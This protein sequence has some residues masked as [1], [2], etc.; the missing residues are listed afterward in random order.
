MTIMEVEIGDA[1]PARSLDTKAALAYLTASGAAAIT[2]IERAGDR[3]A[4][5][6]ACSESPDTA[7]QRARW[8]NLRP[9]RG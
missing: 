4:G 3:Q 1:R 5:P 2:I 6:Q 7:T 9:I 8:R